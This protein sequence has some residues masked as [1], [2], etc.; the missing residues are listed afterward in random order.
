MRVEATAHIDQLLRQPRERRIEPLRQR[1]IGERPRREDRHF[2]RIFM[3]HV[4]QE[5][6][7]DLVGGLMGRVAAGQ[8]DRI[9]RAEIGGRALL[10]RLDPMLHP[11]ALPRELAVQR[12]PAIGRRL[13]IDEREGRALHH[14]HV[15]SVR[16][17]QPAQRHRGRAVRPDIARDGGEAEHLDIGV[18]EQHQVHQPEALVV[19]DDLALG[20]LCV[21]RADGE[22]QRQNHA[23]QFPR[24]SGG[25]EPRTP[26]LLGPGLPPSRENG[27]VCTR[28]SITA[29]PRTHRAARDAS[30]LPRPAGTSR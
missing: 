24:E 14:R 22:E 11:R 26:A 27:R 30:P 10:G 20:R 29:P 7:G 13:G 9:V 12:L 8:I 25:P 4:D 1:E 28:A 15:G 18:F 2:A 21:R 19:D 3:H 16:D 17:F 6:G 5:I 23:H